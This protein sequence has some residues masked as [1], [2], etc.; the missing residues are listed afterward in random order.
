MRVCW[1]VCW[2]GVSVAWGVSDRLSWRGGEVC[3]PTESKQRDM[4]QLE[5]DERKENTSDA[6]ARTEKL[7]H[8]PEPKHCVA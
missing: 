7:G 6:L 1:L 5:P 4:D 2:W 3:E 8:A